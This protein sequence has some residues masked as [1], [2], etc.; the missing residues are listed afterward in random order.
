MEQSK[1]LKLVNEALQINPAL[2]LIALKVTADAKIRVIVDGDDGVP[3]KEC[4]RISRHI[5][6]NLDREVEDYQL[7]VMSAGLSEPLSSVRQ[8]K[9]NVGKVLSL[10]LKD[11]SE[12]EGEVTAVTDEGFDISWEAREPKPVGKGKITVSKQA[13]FKFD[14]IKE[15]KV[16][17]IFN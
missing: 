7:E 10:K 9:K 3:L 11:G 17:I 1:V 8:Y 15:A 4:M 16:K 2:F 13:N 14:A 6:Q 5:E 12:F